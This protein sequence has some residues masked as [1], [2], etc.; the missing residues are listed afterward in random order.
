M[1]VVYRARHLALDRVDAIKVIALD[2]A[3]PREFRERFVR[4]SHLTA[5]L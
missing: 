1:G 5:S 4:E 3:R 2:L